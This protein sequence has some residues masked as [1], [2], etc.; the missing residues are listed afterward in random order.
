MD[1]SSI[2]KNNTLAYEQFDDDNDGK[3][4]R[5]IEYANRNRSIEVEDGDGNGAMDLWTYYEAGGRP[6]GCPGSCEVGVAD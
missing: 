1:L 6:G 5:R 3:V 2:Y 4:N